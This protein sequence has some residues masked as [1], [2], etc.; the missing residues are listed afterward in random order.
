MAGQLLTFQSF[1]DP[2]VAEDV[3][4]LFRENDIIYTLENTSS[5]IDPVIIGSP[6]DAEIKLKI[7]AEDFSKAGKLLDDYYSKQLDTVPPDYYL[8]AFTDTELKEIISKP[9]EWGH[10]DYMLAQK[11][12]KDRGREIS[13]EKAAA[14][15]KD[16][17]IEMAAP[18][19]LGR[20]WIITGYFV[21]IF[22]CILGVIYSA[23]ILNFRKTLPDGGR[24]FGYREEDRKHALNML[25]ISSVLTVLAVFS[26]LFT[27]YD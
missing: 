23:S 4:A 7:P 10:F 26:L 15:K 16:R 18:G 11:L 20:F 5:P 27:A 17:L 1:T 24:V 3:A 6:L 21:A 9:D 19:E 22:F 25:V 14:L 8:F 13:P 12:L 2:A